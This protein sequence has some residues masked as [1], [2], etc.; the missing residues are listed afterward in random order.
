MYAA[1][2]FRGEGLIDQTVTIDPALAFERISHDMYTKVAFSS[3]AMTSVTGMLVGLIL[4][5]QADGRES[6]GQFLDDIAMHG[7]PVGI[8]AAVGPVNDADLQN[9]AM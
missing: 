3:R 8:T 7:H 9:F 1:G 4:H 2:K 6:V 5:T